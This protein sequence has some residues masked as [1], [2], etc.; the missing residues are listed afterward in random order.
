M[1]V[2]GQPVGVLQLFDAKDVVEIGEIQVLRR[3][4]TV[5]S[6][7]AFLLMSSS[8]RSNTGSGPRCTWA[9]KTKAP[10][11]FMSEW[12]LMKQA[13]QIRIFS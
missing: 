11:G 8:V 2:A 3:I 5:A 10:S 1:S 7:R 4:R 6:V 9:S 12:A 13:G